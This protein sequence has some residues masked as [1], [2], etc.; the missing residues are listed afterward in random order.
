MLGRVFPQVPFAKVGH[1]GAGPVRGAENREIDSFVN[2]GEETH[3][4]LARH[5]WCPW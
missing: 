5:V 1:C 4:L 3:C 2:I